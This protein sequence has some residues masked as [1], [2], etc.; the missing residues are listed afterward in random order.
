MFHIRLC[1][2]QL[3]LQLQ[4]HIC[5]V[6]NLKVHSLSRLQSHLCLTLEHRGQLQIQLQLQICV[7]PY[8]GPLHLW[9][10]SL[11]CLTLDH[12][13]STLSLAPASDPY[14]CHTFWG[15]TPSPWLQYHLCLII[16]SW[17]GVNSIYGSRSIFVLYLI[18]GSTP[19]PP[20]VLSMFHIRLC[21]G[22]IPSPDPYLCCTFGGSTPSPAPVP[23]MFHIRLW[24][25]N[26]IYGSS[27]SIHICVVPFEGPLHHHL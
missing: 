3:Y 12:K 27:S 25:V 23:S 26:F 15:P 1:G 21:G 10:Q 18:W 9:L 16:R 22:L 5:V 11:L 19:S 14:L 7:V 2:G 17:G 20:L 24:G 6:P 8:E 13:W 4:I